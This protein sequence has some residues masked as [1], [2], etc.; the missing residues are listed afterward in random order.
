M[1]WTSQHAERWFNL[2]RS[3]RIEYLPKGDEPTY[4]MLMVRC[5]CED[6]PLWGSVGITQHQ[7]QNL[8]LRQCYG[9]VEDLQKCMGQLNKLGM[10][11]VFPKLQTIAV[12]SIYARADD[13]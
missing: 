2:T 7:S 10:R 8:A 12:D 5:P 11:R 4:V 3:L 9:E 13:V 6:Q 1:D